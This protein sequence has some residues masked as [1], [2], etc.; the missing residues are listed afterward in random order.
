MRQLIASRNLRGPVEGRPG[1]ADPVAPP[2]RHLG[3][4]GQADDREQPP[5]RRRHSSNDTADVFSFIDYPIPAST[6]AAPERALTYVSPA[7]S[8]R[9]R[10]EKGDRRARR[11]RRIFSRTPATA[12]ALDVCPRS[13]SG[14]K[15]LI[16]ISSH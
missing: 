2:E 16:S 14:A 9:K 7:G 3:G 6:A 12:T 8:L 11:R 13:T 4:D 15:R 5:A 10:S 1:L